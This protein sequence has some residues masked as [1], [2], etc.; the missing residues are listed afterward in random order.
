MGTKWQAYQH[1]ISGKVNAILVP[2]LAFLPFNGLLH[3][4]DEDLAEIRDI[5]IAPSAF[6]F[7]YL[8]GLS[9]LQGDSGQLWDL[10]TP[11]LDC[12]PSL[13]IDNWGKDQGSLTGRET[14]DVAIDSPRGRV[15]AHE[16]AELVV[17]VHVT[18]D[19]VGRLPKRTTN[20]IRDRMHT[21][22]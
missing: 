5:D 10:D 14:K 22:P 3:E 17:T 13:P 7:A 4:L 18:V 2:K 6:A 20:D 8:D 21:S 9:L 12:T 1:S 19:R 15:L 16:L 11:L